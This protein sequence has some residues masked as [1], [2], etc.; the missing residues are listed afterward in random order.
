MGGV[1]KLY[2]LE[3]EAEITENELIELNNPKEVADKEEKGE[4]SK[5]QE[6]KEKERELKIK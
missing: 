3:E 4:I 5:T 1:E 6:L 2:N